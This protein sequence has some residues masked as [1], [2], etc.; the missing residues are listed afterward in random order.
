MTIIIITTIG[1]ISFW[2]F[3]AQPNQQAEKEKQQNENFEEPP[4]II[5][6]DYLEQ[7]EKFLEN[8]NTEKLKEHKTYES[9][10][11]FSGKVTKGK[12]ENRFLI[13]VKNT[14]QDVIPEKLLQF[15]LIDQAGNTVDELEIVIPSMQPEEMLSLSLS[16]TKELKQVT[17][18]QIKTIEGTV[19]N[20]V[21]E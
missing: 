21:S 14:I 11:F 13:E 18:Y 15:I 16:S 6:N 19:E 5:P 9:Y 3:I 2:L 17:D 1:G 8:K 10:E 20:Y 7:D 12:E 4:P